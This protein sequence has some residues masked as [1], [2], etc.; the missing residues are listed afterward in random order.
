M[1][2]LNNQW[3]CQITC[4]PNK[5][6]YRPSPT[7]VTFEF[8]AQPVWATTNLSTICIFDDD[9]DFGCIYFTEYT[10]H[11]EH[12]D[13]RTIPLDKPYNS[14]KKA[15]RVGSETMTSLTYEADSTNNGIRGIVSTQFWTLS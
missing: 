9:A 4:G 1:W 2:T 7:S 6:T 12:G 8:E 3:D 5:G 14:F 10:E 15:V 13:N 11:N